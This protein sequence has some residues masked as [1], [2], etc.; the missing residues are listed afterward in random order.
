MPTT[1]DGKRIVPSPIVTITKSYKRLGSTQKVKPVF[2]IV[3]NGTILNFKGSPIADDGDADTIVFQTSGGIFDYPAD[4]INF[5]NNDGKSM[6]F[7]K[8]QALRELFSNDNKKLEW[9]MWNGAQPCWC[10]P[11]VQSIDFAEGLWYRRTD[12]KITFEAEF[13]YGPSIDA[14]PTEDIATRD[15][16]NIG[17]GQ[18]F[19]FV[20]QYSLEDANDTISIEMDTEN[21]GV[22]K[23]TRNISAKGYRSL[24]TVG[25][26][27]AEGW[28]NART[29]VKDR[30]GFSPAYLQSGVF[31]NLSGQFLNYNHFRTENTD[32]YNGGY[33]TTETWLLSSGTYYEDFSAETK[34][35]I[36]DPY[37][38]V[39]IQGTINGLT[40]FVVG[41][42]AWVAPSALLKYNNASGA[43]Y[44]S[45]SGTLYTRAQTYLN[46]QLNPLPVSQTV[47]HSFLKGVIGYNSEFNTRPLTFVSGAISETLNIVDDNISGWVD[48]IGEHVVLNRAIGTVLQPIYTTTAPTRAISYEAVFPAPTYGSSGNNIGYLMSLK[49]RARVDELI[50]GLNPTNYAPN[51]LFITQDVENWSPLTQRY[52][53]NVTFKYERLV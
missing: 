48:T 33:S 2:N 49:P 22:F 20:S 44:G 17:S 11:R 41:T 39:S 46:I 47:T 36:T 10:F 42:D 24:D 51:Y 27:I 43:W 37:Q 15:S 14:S 31:G 16:G 52:S 5:D 1:Y 21:F 26:V 19:D 8:Q 12:Y 38:T 7:L 3:I 32:I 40:P 30:M 18:V 4:S 45:I 25:N 53:R 9:V 23:A 50:S 6:L 28:H 35:S 34:N 13:L 29:W